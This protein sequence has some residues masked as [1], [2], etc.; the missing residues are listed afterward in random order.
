MQERPNDHTTKLE[1]S[2]Q[3]TVRSQWRLSQPESQ[4]LL[5]KL[6]Y[7]FEKRIIR[8]S[9]SPYASPF[10]FTPKRDRGLRMCTDYKALNNI[11][12]KSR[13]LLSRVDDLIDQLRGA[14]IF[15]KIY[16]RGGYHQIHVAE[17]DIPKTA[18]RTH[19]KS[20]KCTV[21][22]LGLTNAPSTFQPDHE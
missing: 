5:A 8:P 22:L 16:M 1:P 3:P 12:I 11:T 13:Y 14:K 2:A 10:L 15:S 7:L 21:M 19:Y 17:A 18:S 9:T 4:E 20:Y 6:E